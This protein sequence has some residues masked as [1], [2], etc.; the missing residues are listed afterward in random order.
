MSAE[1]P[2]LAPPP[3]RK[4]RLTP[5]PPPPVHAP[6]NLTTPTD[7]DSTTFQDLNFKVKPEFHRFFK[8]EAVLRGMSMKGLL[9]AMGRCYL[10]RSSIRC[11]A[12]GSEVLRA[13]LVSAAGMVPIS[14]VLVFLGQRRLRLKAKAHPKKKSERGRR[15]RIRCYCGTLS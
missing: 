12:R 2:K 14:A 6:D 8:A 13:I 4:S 5:A 1:A 15:A 7:E 10:A 11:V 9:E 3:P